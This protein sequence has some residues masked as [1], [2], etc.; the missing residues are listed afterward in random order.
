MNT[1]AET[2]SAKSSARPLAPLNTGWA[3]WWM[4]PAVLLRL[5]FLLTFLVYV[6]TITFD[7]VFDDH[8]Q[9]TMNPW[10]ASWGS[11]KQI[12]T[13]HSWAFTDYEVPAKFYRPLYLVWLLANNQ[14]FHGMPGW[15]HLAGVF[16]HLGVV[17]LA[18]LTARRLMKDERLAAIAALLFA[19]HP[20]KVE[21]VAWVAGLTEVLL[22]VFFF[23]TVLAYL[24]WVQGDLDDAD[25]ARRDRWLVT[26]GLCFA[27][28]IFSK[29]TAV[30]APVLI[31]AHY[32]M[33]KTWQGRSREVVKLVSPYVLV[34]IA[35][36]MIRLEV[37]HGVAQLNGRLSASKTI[38]TIPE[39]LWW[40]IGHVVWPFGLSLYYPEM[41]V[42]TASVTAF[43]LPAIALAG[44]AAA[45]WRFARK[46]AT[47]KLM[48]FWFVLTLLPPVVAILLLQPHDRYLYLPT[49][50]FAVVA[51]ML[52]NKLDMTKA[53]LVVGAIVIAFAAGSFITSCYW[54]DDLHI[55]ERAL[56]KAPDNMSVRSLLGG[57]LVDSGQKDRAFSIMLDGY[58][59]HP[60]SVN[61]SFAIAQLYQNQNQFPEARKFLEHTLTLD[62]DER[63]IALCHF[64]MGTMAQ[65]EKNFDEAVLEYRKA[66]A[67]S[68]GSAGFHQSL[69]TVLR[70]QG[71]IA[72]ANEEFEKEKQIRQMRTRNF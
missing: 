52:I 30:L 55:F 51:A 46:S 45:Y 15:F 61:L 57:L 42:R 36:W 68:P 17:Y 65:S 70:V 44:L 64:S 8:L 53:A 41:I 28:A 50:A 34:G 63:V 67:L 48:G 10:L 59:R 31:F 69:G 23:G 25:G 54:E 2:A 60:D 1:A 21:S 14:L 19:L 7:W 71:N 39:A 35:Y 38:L 47:A 24:R 18:F 40:Y 5:T 66:I 20:S 27:G 6:R 56:V 33:S 58:S 26:S 72:E 43:V 29:E 37:M 49:F 12:F 32:W 9:V 22:A 16:L 13:L 3:A 62:A 4:R 11:L